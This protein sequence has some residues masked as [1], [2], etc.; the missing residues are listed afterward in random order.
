MKLTRPLILLFI[1]SLFVPAMFMHA[2]FGRAVV[3]SADNAFTGVLVQSVL[4][5]EFADNGDGT[6]LLTLEGVPDN[7]PYMFHSPN[8]LAG[9]YPTLALA[10]D[11]A[12]MTDLEATAVLETGDLSLDLTLKAPEYDP[13]SDTLTYTAT[14]EAIFTFDTDAKDEPETPAKFDTATLFILIDNDLENGIGEGAVARLEGTRIDG[15]GN[16]PFPRPGQGNDD[17]D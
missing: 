6:F 1:V 9:L 8:R 14:I 17:D 5:G 15:N 11:W 16:S 10:L 7:T 13:G 12:V 4:S 2:L 3:V